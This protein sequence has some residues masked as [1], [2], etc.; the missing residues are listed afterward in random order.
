MPE[1]MIEKE[2]Y[3]KSYRQGRETLIAVCDCE[4]LGHS[5]AEGALHIDVSPDFFGGERASPSE[6]K[7][8][9][10]GAT[11]ANIVGCRSV[12][13]AISLGYVERECVLSIKGIPCAQMVRM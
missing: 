9:L 11:M 10:A 4:V 8:A 5:F 7:S 2:M 13:H 1:E 3:L 12:E 6:I